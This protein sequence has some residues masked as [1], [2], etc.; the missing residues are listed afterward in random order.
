[1]GLSGFRYQVSGIR[2][3]VIVPFLATRG[4]QNYP[5]STSLGVQNNIVSE[6]GIAITK[7]NGSENVSS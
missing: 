4:L 2:F 3:Q 5:A 7:P 6:D 1:L